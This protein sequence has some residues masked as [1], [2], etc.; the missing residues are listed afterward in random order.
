MT[1]R[2]ML[3][4]RS[5]TS[6]ERRTSEISM[7]VTTSSP[8]QIKKEVLLVEMLRDEGPFEKG[9]IAR[10]VEKKA[11]GTYAIK[12]L[13]EQRETDIA[14]DYISLIRDAQLVESLQ[15]TVDSIRRK[16]RAKDKA[17]AKHCDDLARQIRSFD[18]SAAQRVVAECAQCREAPRRVS[19][20]DLPEKAE[21][22]AREE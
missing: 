3:L 19:G 7:L 5:A 21:T 11:A 8:L 14:P 17:F 16:R 10:V 2:Y 22:A 18:V 12:S 9:E 15:D 20:R 1:E 6:K 13:D 4:Y